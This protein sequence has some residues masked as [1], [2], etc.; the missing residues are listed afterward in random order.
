MSTKKHLRLTGSSDISWKDAIV[1]TINQ[2]SK[3]IDYISSVT[4]IEQTAKVDGN[5]IVKYY[6]TMDLSFDIDDRG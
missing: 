3:S 4:L 2:A 1:Q 6:A 5:K